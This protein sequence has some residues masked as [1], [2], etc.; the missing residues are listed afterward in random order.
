MLDMTFSLTDPC[1][2]SFRCRQAGR[3][4]AEQRSIGGAEGAVEVDRA[5]ETA[6][7]AVRYRRRGLGIP[8]V[9]ARA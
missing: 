5:L 6:T 1:A 4:H 9:R 2:G 3:A 8:P 7:P